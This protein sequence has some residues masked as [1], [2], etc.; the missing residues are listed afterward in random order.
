MKGGLAMG[1]NYLAAESLT[2]CVA[3]D[4]QL[5]AIF[6]TIFAGIKGNKADR[7]V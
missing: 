5:D 6:A 2:A 7:V 1:R 4:C 3:L